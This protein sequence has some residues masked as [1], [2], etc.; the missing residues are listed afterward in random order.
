MQID[1]QARQVAPLSAYIGI[2]VGSCLGALLRGSFRQVHS[3]V[4]Y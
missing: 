4:A 3:E 2:H 1:H